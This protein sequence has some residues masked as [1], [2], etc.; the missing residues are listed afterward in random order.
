[1]NSRTTPALF[2]DVEVCVDAILARVGKDV[3]LGLPLGLG[4]PT[5]LVNALY[6]RARKDPSLKL[7]IV[8]AL[9]LEKPSGK[10]AFEKNFLG[11][12]VE[13][14]FKGVPDLDYVLDLRRQQLPPNV[15]VKEFFF[16]AGSYLHHASQQQNYISSNYT[17]VARDLLHN[18][19]NVVAQMVSK[20][21][22]DGRVRYSLSCNPDV[23]LDL[24]P[25]LRELQAKGKSVAI[26][27]EVNRKLP[28]MYHD[29][30]V[31]G[32][33]FDII[34]DNPKYDHPLFAAP[35][36]AITPADH[37]IG[38]Y[39]STLLKDGGTLQVGIGSLGSALVYSTLVRHQHNAEYQ[40]LMEQL[41]VREKFPVV[42]EIGGDRPF[43]EGLY[44]CSEMMVDGF[45]HLYRAGVL[46]REVFGDERLQNLINQGRLSTT[47]TPQT[48][49][50]LVEE[51]IIAAQLRAKDLAF[52]QQWGILTEMVEF[53]GGA[54]VVG[55][56]TI[57]PDLRNPEVLQWIA[58]HCLGTRLKGG[59]V[60]HGGFYLGPK[61]L[62]Q[63][64][65]ELT[66]ED[67][68]KFCMTSV[69]FINHLYDHFL[70]RQSLKV[71]QRKEARFINSTMLVTLNGAAVSDGLANAQVISGVGGQYN[72]VAMGHEMPDSRSILKFKSTRMSGGRLLSNI[73]L[74]YGHS[75]IPRHLRDLYVTEYGI[76][77]VRGK[78]DKDVMIELIKIAD[79]R[80]QDELLNQ[81]KAAG[82]IP[83]DY[84]LPE[85]Y[86][87]NTPEALATVLGHA[88]KS[89]YFPPFPFGCDFTEDEL[90]IG[91]ALKALKAKTGSRG[92]LARAIWK[93]LSAQPTPEIM[94]LLKRMNMEHPASI[95]E[96]L[97]QK[98]LISELLG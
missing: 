3:T 92:G 57:D 25:M 81:A 27:A 84:V 22:A 82:K 46:K 43:E 86:R 94:P 39:A 49:S 79:S 44:G 12:F 59:I 17:H 32:E 28:F 71:S 48:L 69:C 19:V 41:K 37:M 47:V 24:Q 61:E 13:R 64:L 77:D 76:A 70:G 8:T 50:V 16:K 96:K 83:A 85:L 11:P 36:M 31:D 74:S 20:Q 5:H 51:G 54:L 93:A 10:S 53:K 68:Q 38:F 80:F 91:K 35:N 26:V 29:A 23:S 60:M 88:T 42:D 62:Y 2:A 30:I 14:Q 98:L 67:H 40:H 95:K 6:Q 33:Q 4:K 58:T 34:L 87:H 52:L 66:Y 97:E 75:T 7:T 72:F 9:S 65:E 45:L 73:V 18:G 55:R 1:M 90:R 78:S 15:Q 56:E 63:M 21:E 89:G